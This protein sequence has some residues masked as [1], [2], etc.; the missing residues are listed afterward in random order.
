[1]TVNP[2]SKSNHYPILKTEDIFATLKRGN[3][4]GTKLDLS[5]AYL[6]LKLE[7][8][9]WSLIP[10]EASSAT[11]ACLM[12]SPLFPESDGAVTT[13][14]SGLGRVC[15]NIHKVLYYVVHDLHYTRV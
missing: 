15:N 14:K 6:Q 9:T 4:F 1:M 11:H 3:L 13:G 8:S 5:Q 10:T 7:S 2:V 12:V